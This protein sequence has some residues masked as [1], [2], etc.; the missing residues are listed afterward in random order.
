MIYYKKFATCF[1]IKGYCRSAIYDLDRRDVWS[2]DRKA[3]EVLSR[4]T[5]PEKLLHT[6]PREIVKDLFEKEVIFPCAPSDA[7]W[8]P[9][10]NTE[11]STPFQIVSSIIDIEHSS[12]Y[13]ICKTIA[14]LS[15]LG[16]KTL[17]IRLSASAPCARVDE[18]LPI[19][20]GKNIRSVEL[21]MRFENINLEELIKKHQRVTS[22]AMYQAPRRDFIQINGCSIILTSE[23]YLGAEQCGVVEPTHFVCNRE[24]FIESL[25]R[26]T[27]L[28]KKISV[29]VKGN[30]KSCP[31]CTQ[32]FGNIRN[33][34]LKEAMEHPDFKKLWSISKDQIDV[35]KDCEYRH[36]CTDCRAHIKDPE[37]IHSQPAKCPYNPYIAKWAGEDGYIPVEEC[38]IYSKEKG[39]IANEQKINTINMQLWGG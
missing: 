8:F 12:D 25:S 33:T 6:L 26:N 3:Y 36:M 31:S 10:I 37:N 16:C 39:F 19:I 30:I 29:D 20:E 22:I 9:P 38:G 2:I 18:I 13:D 14:Q 23:D 5:I 11:W 24:L 27:C 1:P 34:T 32:T 7:R 21:I 15:E 17:Q 4:D 35:C 28:N